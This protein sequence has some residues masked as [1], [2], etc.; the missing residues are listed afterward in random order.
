MT[1]SGSTQAPLPFTG[2]LALAMLS[3]ATF[4]ILRASLGE[5]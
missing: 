4:E 2:L 5:P 1:V 3:L